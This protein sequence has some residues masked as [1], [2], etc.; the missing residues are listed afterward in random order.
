[1]SATIDERVVEMRFDNKQFEDGVQTSMSTLERLRKSLNLEG[2]TKGLEAVD[3]AAKKCKMTPLG[4]AVDAVKVK[5]SAMQVVAAT[6]ITNITNSA[7]NMGKRLVKSLTVDPISDGFKEYELK[8]DSV[9]NIMNGTGESLETVM[10][11][12]N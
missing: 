11:Y 3:E 6:A 9:Q 10:K 2:A 12:L 7:I 1:M 4:D 8:M 5:F